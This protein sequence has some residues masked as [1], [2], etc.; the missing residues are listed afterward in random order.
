MHETA[1]TVGGDRRRIESF[2][3][4]SFH[5]YLSLDGERRIVECNVAAERLFGLTRHALVG[6]RLLP[7]IAN[8]D[9]PDIRRSVE[10]L[11]A[12][13]AAIR[14]PRRAE[15]AIVDQRGAHI[16]VEMSV[17]LCADVEHAFHV[18]VREVS[19]QERT[20]ARLRE[21]ETNRQAILD[22][23][24]ESYCEVDLSGR[25][26]F[27]NDAFCRRT[28][29][30]RDE[31]IGRKFSEVSSITAPEAVPLLKE[32]FHRV[33]RTGEPVR[34]FEFESRY[35]VD[36]MP[37]FNEISV[38]LRRNADGEPIGFTSFARDTTE[39]LRH[40]RELSQAKLDAEAANRAKSEFLANMSHEIR[41]PMNGIIGM[42]ELVLGTNLTPYQVEGL[43]IVK[44]SAESLL[45]IL[46]DVLDFSKI[47]SRKLELESQPFMV[48]ELVRRTLKPAAVTAHEKGLELIGDI[49]PGVPACM[50][51]DAGRVVQVLTNLVG[52]AIKFT[53]SGHV[54]LT[55]H[56]DA[57][58]IHFR[59]SDTGIGIAAEKQQSIFE[60]FA[61][62]EMSTTRR[63]GGTGLGLTISST[64]VQLMHGR[65]W[66][67][68]EPGAG[69]T[70]HVT[71]PCIEAD[72]PPTVD[73]SQVLHSVRSLIVDDSAVNRRIF[74]EQ[75]RG[76]GMEPT[77]VDGGT[78]AIAA[79]ADARA[80]GLPYQLVL[81]D[82]NMPDLDG[83]QVAEQIA[84][85]K[86]YAGAT[87]MMLTSS[88]Q[89]G[90]AA[91]CHQLGIASYLIKPV[92]G[93]ELMM[94][95]AHLLEDRRRTA[96]ASAPPHPG[97]VEMTPSPRRVLL[98]EDNAINQKVA[99]GI[100]S[101]RGHQ[102]TVVG[103]G[104]EAVKA[105]TDHEFD[106]VL[107]DVQMP[108]MDGF[109]ATAAIRALPSGTARSVRIVAMTAHAMQGD[110][111]RCL[112]AGMDDYLAKPLDTKVLIRV[113]ETSKTIR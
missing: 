52:N 45:R 3:S 7:L 104:R 88:G 20:E 62:A 64:L 83:F 101:R 97:A 25:Y 59:V 19:S 80:R 10:Q 48:A 13:N 5:P 14:S 1:A 2:A 47:E 82:A 35:S 78:A 24:Q 66:V 90:D 99:V 39:R 32:V 11:L 61:Q 27:V 77:A 36:G 34:S 18:F 109:E 100:L 81:L 55:V 37:R 102:V 89:Y 28:G 43:T 65:I 16:S 46:N 17:A 93:L 92:D 95:I 38:C 67:E 73:V 63:F 87:I 84:A 69:S 56:K 96:I 113:V 60:P 42:T 94:A 31:V 50:L 72:P 30:T 12:A 98:A 23:I 40:E 54:M 9:E 108:E 51:G 85:D 26:T 76:W 41:T 44:A 70:F 22:Q 86:A 21:S 105:L 49:A 111:E 107:M 110:R 33:Y 68:S 74:V 75:L 57:D 29:V 91:R 71:L 15:L 112:A 8:I 6:R 53:L 103:T 106:L 58:S 4:A 79:L